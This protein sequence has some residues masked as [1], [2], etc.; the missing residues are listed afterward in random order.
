[1]NINSSSLTF[2]FIIC[3]SP[4]M[5]S[6]VLVSQK[7]PIAYVAHLLASTTFASPKPMTSSLSDGTIHAN[8][9]SGSFFMPFD[10]TSKAHFDKNFVG[11][12]I[13]TSSQSKTFL[14]TS[15][16]ASSLINDDA[17]AF[18]KALVVGKTIQMSL[19]MALL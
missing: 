17:H 3:P 18:F 10:G 9:H 7:D 19:F 12:S 11:S 6:Y 4:Y 14:N 2:A 5:V 13:T 16:V 8:P 15:S 1:M